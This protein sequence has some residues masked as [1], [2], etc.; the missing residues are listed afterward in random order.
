MELNVQLTLQHM[1][2]LAVL[3]VNMTASYTEVKK[4]QKTK[5]QPSSFMFFFAPE[6]KSVSDL[7]VQRYCIYPFPPA[8]LVTNRA[9][10]FAALKNHTS[11]FSS[12][13]PLTTNLI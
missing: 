13:I 10:L 3:C 9:S 12:L 5:A 2:H 7:Q 4:K 1:A 11:N 8:N 6:S